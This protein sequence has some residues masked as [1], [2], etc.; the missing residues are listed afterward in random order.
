[1]SSYPSSEHAA[2]DNWAAPNRAHNT[3][4][5]GTHAAP[6]GNAVSNVAKAV[7]L[8]VTAPIAGGLLRGQTGKALVKTRH[9]HRGHAH[10]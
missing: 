7:Q 6:V 5:G 10:L 3:W 4:D 2:V 8:Q 9:G 1:M